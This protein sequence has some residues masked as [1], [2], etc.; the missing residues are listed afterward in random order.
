MNEFKAELGSLEHC[1][2]SAAL[3]I[4][5]FIILPLIILIVVGAMMSSFSSVTVR[6]WPS[7]FEDYHSTL[8]CTARYWRSWLA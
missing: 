6:I 2:K 4:V 3:A 1:L 5:K 8:S 7:L